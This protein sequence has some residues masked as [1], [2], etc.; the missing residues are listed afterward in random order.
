MAL[1][2]CLGSPCHSINTF[3]HYSTDL[4]FCLQQIRPIDKK[5]HYQIEKLTKVTAS[6]TENIQQSEKESQSNKTADLLSYRPNPEM[7]P[8]NTDMTS[9]V[10]CI[11][12]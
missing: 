1:G 11:S 5:L 6:T 12:L 2:I 10:K 7:I 3:S 4:P 8:R 9:E